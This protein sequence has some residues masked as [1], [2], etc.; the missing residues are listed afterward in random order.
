VQ[1]AAIAAEGVHEQ[2][3]GGQLRR[4]HLVVKECL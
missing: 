4:R 1:I 2:E 3:F